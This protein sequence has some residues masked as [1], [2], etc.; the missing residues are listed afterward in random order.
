MILVFSVS[1]LNY[2]YFINNALAQ[3]SGTAPSAAPGNSPNTVI[4]LSSLIQSLRMQVNE[5]RLALQNNNIQ[6]ALMHL[7]LV[8]N[9]L[10]ELSM[11][12]ARGIINGTKASVR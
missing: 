1:A 7:K 11:I 6:G 2:Y 12:N 10:A 9:Q 5:T 4:E 8:D 3:T